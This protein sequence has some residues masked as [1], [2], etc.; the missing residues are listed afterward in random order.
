MSS[1][2]SLTVLLAGVVNPPAGTVSDF[3]VSTSSDSVPADAPPYTIGASVG[4]NVAV[5][6]STAGALGT[7]TISDLFATA[8]LPAGS[9]ITI[10]AP[11][12]TVFPNNPA[13]YTVQDSTTPSASGVVT[14]ALSGGGTNSVT[15]KVPGSINAGDQLTLVVQ[16]TINPSTASTLVHDRPGGGCGRSIDGGGAVPAR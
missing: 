1:G 2:D 4:V 5:N 6:P 13:E 12:G 7:Y 16:D 15:V 10:E 3:T 9:S 11:A 14:G 8:A